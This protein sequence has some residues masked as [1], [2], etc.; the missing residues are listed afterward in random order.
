VSFRSDLHRALDEVTPPAPHLPHTVMQA[1][2]EGR[3]PRRSRLLPRTAV[4]LAVVLSLAVIG[5]GL[6]MFTASSREAVPSRPGAAGQSQATPTPVEQL[7][8]TTWTPDPSASYPNTPYPGYRPAISPITRSMVTGA[9]VAQDPRAICRSSSHCPVVVQ[10]KFESQ[11]TEIFRKLMAQAAAACPQSDCPPSHLT[12][13]INL[14]QDD[15]A[16]WN[17]RAQQLYRPFY[18]GGKL[19]SDQLVMSPGTDANGFSVQI[20]GNFNQQ[21]AED[22]AQGLKP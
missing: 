8:V 12:M 11:G 4:V 1:V 6:A 20:A 10:I 3:T 13:W 17:Q 18:E 15:V 7:V 16:H 19:L 9:S 21:Q 22:L 14:T 5:A 2:R